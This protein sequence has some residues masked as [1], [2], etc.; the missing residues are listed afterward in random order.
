MKHLLSDFS[1]PKDNC[2][3]AICE[4]F[5]YLVHATFGENFEQIKK[6]ENQVKENLQHLL[7]ELI[8]PLCIYLCIIWENVNS[9]FLTIPLYKLLTQ[10]K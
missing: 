9:I 8:P 6:E 10:I 5:S 2:S 1:T 7:D 3:E 4:T